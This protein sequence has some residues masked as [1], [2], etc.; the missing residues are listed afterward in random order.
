[1]A[2]DASPYCTNEYTHA[3]VSRSMNI[4][5]SRRRCNFV[6]KPVPDHGWMAVH[7]W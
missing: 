3:R 2:V 6:W 5:C 4:F 7:H 1:M